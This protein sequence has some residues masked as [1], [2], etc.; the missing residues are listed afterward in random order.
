MI[1]LRCR[2]GATDHAGSTNTSAPPA[3]AAAADAAG[4]GARL[5]IGVVVGPEDEESATRSRAPPR[6]R[7]RLPCSRM[8]MTTTAVPPVQVTAKTLRCVSVIQQRNRQRR[9]DFAGRKHLS[10]PD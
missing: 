9:A 8:T 3:A 6:W 5:R 4:N 2:G 7:P 1:P 10:S